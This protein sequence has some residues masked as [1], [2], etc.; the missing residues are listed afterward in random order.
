MILQRGF[1][2]WEQTALVEIDIFFGS[3]WGRFVS[4][5]RPEGQSAEASK[6]Q[7]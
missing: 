5:G 4:F 7:F 6:L 1:A 3:V 2:C